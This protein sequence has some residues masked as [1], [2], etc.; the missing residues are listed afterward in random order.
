MNRVEAKLQ[1]EINRL[2]KDRDRLAWAEHHPDEM[3]KG[4]TDWWSSTPPAMKTEFFALRAIIDSAK[5]RCPYVEGC[6]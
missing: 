6:A 1:A 5:E 3:L 2:K 4:I